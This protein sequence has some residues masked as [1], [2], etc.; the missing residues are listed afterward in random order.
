MTATYIKREID[1]FGLEALA[2]LVYVGCGLGVVCATT[3]RTDH[4]KS[5]VDHPLDVIMGL[6]GLSS[7]SHAPQDHGDQSV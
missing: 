3:R 7:H 6:V 4:S 1:M 2:A 5:F